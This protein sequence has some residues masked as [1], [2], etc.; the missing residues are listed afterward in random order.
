MAT[1]IQN[2]KYLAHPRNH[3]FWQAIK[4]SRKSLG[5]VQIYDSENEFIKDNIIYSPAELKKIT[6]GKFVIKNNKIVISI[7]HK[8]GIVDL[9]SAKKVKI[10]LA[11]LKKESQRVIYRFKNK[12]NNDEQ[13]I[14]TVIDYILFDKTKD[15]IKKLLDITLHYEETSSKRKLFL[16]VYKDSGLNKFK[17]YWRQYKKQIEYFKSLVGEGDVKVVKK[18]NHVEIIVYSN[19][20]K[21]NIVDIWTE[22]VAPLLAELPGYQIKNRPL[23][24]S[25]YQENLDNENAYA[26]KRKIDKSQ[27]YKMSMDDTDIFGKVDKD[28]RKKILKRIS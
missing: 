28:K 13:I 27:P 24:D 26:T 10:S 19:I 22:Q 16:K 11:E 21:Q 7:E 17:N 25:N 14:G 18:N 2:L 15:K 9:V 12:L 8:N 5:L 1:I 23:K 20:S 6:G 3:K 4:E